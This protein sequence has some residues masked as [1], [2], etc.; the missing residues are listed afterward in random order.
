MTFL[1]SINTA[2]DRSVFSFLDVCFQSTDEQKL[3]Y[4]GQLLSDT[5][6]LKDVLRQYEGQQAHTV[7]L[8]YTPKNIIYKKSTTMSASK[9]TDTPSTTAS[10]AGTTSTTASNN[11]TNVASSSST[12][13]N[14]SDGLR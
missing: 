2:I 10:S 7:H 14:N 1:I 9:K 5:V 13:A 6:V 12:S 4:S 8:V 3:I 11:V